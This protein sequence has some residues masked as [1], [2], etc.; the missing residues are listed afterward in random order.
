MALTEDIL[1]AAL[2]HM[3][4]L[5]TPPLTLLIHPKRFADLRYEQVDMPAHLKVLHMLA[6][7]SG[8]EFMGTIKVRETVEIED[9]EIRAGENPARLQ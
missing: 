4:E 5:P 8:Y 6:D 2:K 3:R 1:G 7:G 9:W